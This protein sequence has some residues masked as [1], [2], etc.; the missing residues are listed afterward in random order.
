M[1]ILCNEDSHLK[2]FTKNV[3]CVSQVLLI[4]RE[5][6]D[7]TT[8]LTPGNVILTAVLNDE[9]PSFGNIKKIAH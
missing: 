4:R 2:P 8:V 6:L 3:A 5:H 7:V 9:F 1:W